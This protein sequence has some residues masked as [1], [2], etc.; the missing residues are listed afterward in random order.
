M[1]LELRL[2]HSNNRGALLAPKVPVKEMRDS[3]KQRKFTECDDRGD[4]GRETERF[5]GPVAPKCHWDS[6]MRFRFK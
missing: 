2:W 6:D 5:R 1:L 4:L 3:E